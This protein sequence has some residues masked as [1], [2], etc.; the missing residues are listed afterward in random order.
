M[1]APDH[2]HLPPWGRAALPAPPPF[3]LR[4][5][6][7]TV[8]P[9]VIALGVAI[10]S[11]E[12]LL[13]PSVVVRYG[14]GLLWITTVAVVLQ[15][16]LNLEMAR[17]TLYT[18]EP[19]VVGFMRTWPGPGFWGWAYSVLCFFHIGWPG[20]ALASATATA[21]LVLGRLPQPGDA[22]L[23][24]LLGY[25]TF[26]ACLLIVTLGRKI[27]RSLEWAMW[28][29]MAAVFGYLLVVDIATVSGANWVRLARG[30]ASVGA[31]PEGVDWP[32]VG[33]FAAYSGLGGMSN[34]F[35]TH[36]LRDKGFGMA[37]T[38]G[39]IPGALGGRLGLAPRG[40]VFDVT[41]QSLGAWRGWWR[42]LNVDQW[43]I[44]G[45]GAIL[46]MSLTCVLT[47]EYVPPGSGVGDWAVAGMQAS[48]I[49][50]A[51]GRPFWYLTLLCGL[52]VLFST[53]LGNMEGVPRMVTDMLWSGSARVRRW[54]G[55]DVRA[56][57]YA[58]L[59]VFAVWA[60]IALGLARPLVLI[61]LGANAAGV[62]FLVVSLHTLRL[63]R[64]FLPPEL[65]PS[66]WR[67]A[68]LVA[69]ALFYASFALGALVSVV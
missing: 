46:G 55:G 21:A 9:G 36:W 11:G 69:C 32:L 63:N 35:I 54:C 14:T 44:F 40:N 67:E 6:L 26:A 52:W 3:T 49:A 62:I 64:K 29:L 23:V 18:G 22:R 51:L 27:E 7:A 37:A 45:A 68:A 58:V 60:F 2:G 65:R 41:P 53:Q 17:Y 38:V 39:Y 4:N 34:V 8:G 12:W 20:W 43:G 56:V 59:G 50:E 42:F 10:G 30:L 66:R 61:V 1:P 48:R 33:A 5:V 24:I 13:G 57:Y 15:V 47:L 19:V 25:A 16:L 31:F 28:I